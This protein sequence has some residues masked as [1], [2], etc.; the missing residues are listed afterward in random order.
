MAEDGVE[1]PLGWRLLIPARGLELEIEP[2]FDDAAQ[3]LS[4]ASIAAASGAWRGAVRVS[5][6]GESDAISGSGR[7]DLNGSTAMASKLD[8]SI[9]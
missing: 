7:M 1:Y 5:G 8:S 6:Q 2:L 9:N 3:A 4:S